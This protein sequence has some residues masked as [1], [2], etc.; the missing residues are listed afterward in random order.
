ME[1][2][3]QLEAAL[4]EIVGDD[5]REARALEVIAETR[6]LLEKSEEEYR[7]LVVEFMRVDA[8]YEAG[9]EEFRA[10]DRKFEEFW[11][12]LL[13][14]RIRLRFALHEQLTREEWSRAAG[15]LDDPGG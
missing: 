10:L 6:S 4:P 5:E 7:A 12:R 2:L 3:A 11:R 13:K 8:D 14:D 9:I 15:E 1:T